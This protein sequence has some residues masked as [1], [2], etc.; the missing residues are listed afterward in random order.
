M[1]CKPRPLRRLDAP[2]HE[3][4]VTALAEKIAEIAYRISSAKLRSYKTY[5]GAEKPTNQIWATLR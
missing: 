4:V 3:R 1:N 5:E 2:R